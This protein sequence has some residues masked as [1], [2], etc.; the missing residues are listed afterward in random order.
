MLPI[1]YQ[2]YFK[3]E[4][5]PTL[6]PEFVPYDNTKNPRPEL[7]EWYIWDQM[8]TQV[9]H[10]DAWGFVSHKFTEKTGITGKQ[11]MDHIAAN[12]DAD[13]WFVNPC[14]LNESV[15]A[16]SWE[17][18]DLHHPGI[19]EI[20][21]TFLR[22]LGW[23]DPDVKS[24]VLD[25]SVTMFANYVVGT[26]KFWDEFMEFSRKLFTEADTDPEFKHSVFGAGVS[27]Y[28]P[29]PSLPMFTFLI[30][31]LIPTFLDSTD[32]KTAPYVYE[33]YQPKYLP[34]AADIAAL[35]DLKIK[36]NEYND[37]ALYNIWNYYRQTFLQ[38]NPGV[39]GLE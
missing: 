25:R 12:P 5:E 16:N 6:D 34:Y 11:F 27:N 3:P 17:Q 39:L 38:R 30:E 4:Q 23:D 20:G 8:Y 13:V 2:I 21:N 33:Q 32:F 36:V 15:F 7:R 19:S 31:R 35:S 9:R 24:L 28:I 26:R 37:D 18:G 14:V 10:Q 29:D 22:K 1:I